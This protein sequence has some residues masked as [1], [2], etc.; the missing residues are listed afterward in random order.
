VGR[1]SGSGA[2]EAVVVAEAVVAEAVV[3]EAVVAEAVVAAEAEVAVSR[4]GWCT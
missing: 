1:G 2:E 3:A 4:Q